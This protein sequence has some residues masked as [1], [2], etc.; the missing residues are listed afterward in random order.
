M[1]ER[2]RAFP[3]CDRAA[4]I[5][6]ASARLNYNS[7]SI[8][9]EGQPLTSESNLPQRNSVFGQPGLF[10]YHGNSAAWP[11]FL[12]NENKKESRVAIVNETFAHKFF[13][14][15]DPIGKRFNSPG[16]TIRSARSSAWCRMENTIR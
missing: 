4:F 7:T 2:V 8:Y 5:D 3:A 1:L 15:Q 11:R 9:I 16:L 10:R 12:P 13:N 6:N 14:G